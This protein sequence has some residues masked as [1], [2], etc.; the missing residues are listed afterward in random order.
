MN[1]ERDTKNQ[2]SAMESF[3]LSC[4]S[5]NLSVRYTQAGDFNFPYFYILDIV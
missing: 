1:L 2:K 4:S 5:I 3:E